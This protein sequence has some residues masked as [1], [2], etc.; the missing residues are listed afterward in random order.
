MIMDLD[1]NYE[2]NAPKYV[3]FTQADESTN[4]NWFGK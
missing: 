2:F 4:D 1:I 3:D